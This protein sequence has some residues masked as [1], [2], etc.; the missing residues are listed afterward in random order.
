V[1]VK[2]A[3][4]ARPALYRLYRPHRF[5]DVVGQTRTV[6]TLRAAVAHGRLTHAYLF[7]GPRGTGKTSVARILAQAVNCE[8]PQAGEPCGQCSSCL[9]AGEG[10]HLDI[11]EVDAA[12][13]RGIDEIR[14]IKE[15]LAHQPVMGRVKTY[16][17]DEV[18]ML[19]AE[20]FNALLKTL[21]EP[22][23]H[24]MFILATTEPQKLP[25]TVIS[26]CQRYEFE[27]LSTPVIAR[28]LGLVLER[29]GVEYQPEALEVL[30]DA[31]DGA[32]RDALSLAD[33]ALAESGPV[34]VE[35]AHQLVGSLDRSRLDRLLAAFWEGGPPG[36]A[37][38]LAEAYHEGAEV[39]QVLR[40][41]ARS[42]RDLMIFR[43]AGAEPFPGYRQAWLRQWAERVPSDIGVEAWV[44]AIEALAEA[45]GR[46]RG[47]FPPLLVAELG[48]Y[49]AQRI[50]QLRE[51]GRLTPSAPAVEAPLN[52][53]PAPAPAEVTRPSSPAASEAS[54]TLPVNAGWAELLKRLRRS[55]RTLWALLQ[56]AEVTLL[57]ERVVITFRY[58]A[59]RDLFASAE[60][61]SFFEGAFRQVYG[62]DMTYEV[63][64]AGEDPV[65]AVP[66]PKEVKERVRRTLGDEVR[67]S[68]FDG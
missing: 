17:I 8:N 6:A 61:K 20:A 64:V 28:H 14:D 11:I 25:A 59:H 12:S 65:A 68:G 54:E 63:R 35:R 26:R 44:G 30:A 2:E 23:E 22:P 24:V 50:L 43:N 56:Q 33:Q 47:G 66:D 60:T 58:P 48:L 34:T 32:L 16:I 31:A 38:A 67:L 9:A 62:A 19:T 57:G 42:L 45:E 10:R 27:R 18:H 29:E 13:N 15:R 39:R 4:M 7:S 41:I 52:P 3:A 5:A 49:K 36:V 46:L 51:S 37:S 53:E 55:R 40:D 1:I 21:E